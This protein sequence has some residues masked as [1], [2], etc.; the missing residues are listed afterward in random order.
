MGYD[1]D[2]IERHRKRLEEAINTV[3]E[4]VRNG[5]VQAT[6]SWMAQRE[7]A[8]KLLKKRNASVSELISAIGSLQ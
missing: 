8:A 6:R 7:Q 5:S 3:P 1:Q 2:T 4:R